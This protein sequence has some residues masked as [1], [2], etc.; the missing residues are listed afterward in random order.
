MTHQKFFFMGDEQIAEKLERIESLLERSVSSTPK[1]VM[2]IEE[3]SKYLG[4]KTS[5]LYRLT[6]SNKIPFYKPGHKVFFKRSE[7]EE[8]VFN[9]RESTHDEIEKRALNYLVNNR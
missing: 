6:S 4:F 7:L 1:E 9:H 3:A 8:W 5:Y 2:T